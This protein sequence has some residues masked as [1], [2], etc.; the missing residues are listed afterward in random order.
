MHPDLPGHELFTQTYFSDTIIET[1]QELLAGCGEDE[2]VMELYNLLVRPDHDF[3]LKWHRD[4]VSI[5]AVVQ[6]GVHLRLTHWL[7]PDPFYCIVR[8]R[9]EPTQ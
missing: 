2:L 5:V 6:V 1:V 7:R 3:E 4:D 9:D 8:R